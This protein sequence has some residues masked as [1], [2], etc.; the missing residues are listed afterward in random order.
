MVPIELLFHTSKDA[1]ADR[2]YFGPWLSDTDS[3]SRDG[4]VLPVFSTHLE[5]WMS[6]Q[7]KWQWDN[8]GKYAGDEGFSAFLESR[9]C[10]R[11][12]WK[13]FLIPRLRRRPCKH[14]STNRDSWSCLAKRASRHARGQETPRVS[15]INATIPACQGP[16]PARR[17]DNMGRVP[18]LRLLVAGPVCCG[19]GSLRAAVS[20][21]MGRT[22]ALR[23]VSIKQSSTTGTLDEEPSATRSELEVTRQQIRKFIRDMKAHLRKEMAVCRQELRAQWVLE[24]LPLIETTPSLEHKAAKNDSS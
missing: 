17:T 8:R 23:C 21:G 7:H 6:F 18:Q 1:E 12:N 20:Q 22:T 16:T 10:T 24:Q 13:W 14:G 15:Q 3:C 19:N 2:E 5:D 9:T 4:N 11:E